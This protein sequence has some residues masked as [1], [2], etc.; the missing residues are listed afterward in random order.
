MNDIKEDPTRIT[1]I[2]P[3][4]SVLKSFALIMSPAAHTA[5]EKK[6]KIKDIQLSI[7]REKFTKMTKPSFYTK[8]KSLFIRNIL[9][10]N[11]LPST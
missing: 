7:L 2:P 6:G 10:L 9:S 1:E 11:I 4:G 5:K 3:I 8:L